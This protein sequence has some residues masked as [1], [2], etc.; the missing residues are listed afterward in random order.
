MQGST[1]RVVPDYWQDVDIKV[2]G[3]LKLCCEQWLCKCPRRTTATGRLE[4]TLYR[5]RRLVIK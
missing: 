1:A 3:G 2:K 4:K 5:L